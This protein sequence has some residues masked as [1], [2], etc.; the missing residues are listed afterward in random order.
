MVLVDPIRLSSRLLKGKGLII[1]EI[2]KKK[3]ILHSWSYYRIREMRSTTL[4]PLNLSLSMNGEISLISEE[5]LPNSFIFL[6]FFFFT[7]SSPL[8]HLFLWGTNTSL[9]I[10]TQAHL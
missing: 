2:K 4:Q 7:K 9:V 1:E 5:S 8:F 6:F 3:F 10:E